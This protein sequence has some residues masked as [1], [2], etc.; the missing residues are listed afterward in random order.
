MY[1]S[2]IVCFSKNTPFLK[3]VRAKLCLGT[4]KHATKPLPVVYSTLKGGMRRQGPRLTLKL[5]K[6]SGLGNL[7]RQI[8]GKIFRWV[9]K[10]KAGQTCMWFMWC[11]ACAT[12]NVDVT[13]D[14]F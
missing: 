11:G 7:T 5:P 3:P 6:S 10:R 13:Q 4:G 2:D 1:F 8:L 14:I 9:V 12:W